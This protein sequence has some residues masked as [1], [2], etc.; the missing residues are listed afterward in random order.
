M[1]DRAD[2][3]ERLR[4]SMHDKLWFTD[5]LRGD[6][7]LFVDFGCADG[8]LLRNVRFERLAH[9][10]EFRG[11][12]YDHDPA[13]ASL[14]ARGSN[15]LLDFT[16]E[17]GW[18]EASVRRAHGEGHKSC[19]VLSS[20]VHEVLT[21][22]GDEGFKSFWTLV[23]NLG[24]DYIAIR[25]MAV[26]AEA[27]RRSPDVS[28]TEAVCR[29]ADI[30]HFLLHGAR[31]PGTFSSQ[32]ELLEG[33]LKANYRD[34]WQA[35]YAERYFPLSSEQWLNWTTIGS[36]YKLRHFEHTP[37]PFHQARWR[38]RY[39]VTVEDPTH[40]KMLLAKET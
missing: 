6:V 4:G 30:A 7:T 11:I 1:L 24:T 2:Y 23:R 35:E 40:I 33:L 3:A 5:L 9:G 28:I 39:G 22:T 19:L 18:L 27:L 34:N 26:E 29:N 21:L 38:R 32:A 14:A 17:F 25:D 10:Y 20:V 8:A 16:Q 36:G 13:M 15:F 37:L 12:G 31:E